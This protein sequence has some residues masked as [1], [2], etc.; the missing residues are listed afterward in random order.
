MKNVLI[1]SLI[2]C[3]IATPVMAHASDFT[4]NPMVGAAHNKAFGSQL[5]LG[6]E[7]GYKDFIL[8]Y[9]INGDKEKN[10]AADYFPGMDKDDIEMPP[11]ELGAYSNEKYRAHQLYMGY[12][13]DTGPGKLAF[14]AGAE[15]SKLK[16][17]SGMSASELIPGGTG[18][19]VGYDASV[20]SNTVIRPMVGV[21]YYLDNGL[22][23]NLHYTFH[24][25]DR[26]MKGSADFYGVSGAN[27]IPLNG[28]IG[29]KDFST[30]MFTVGYRF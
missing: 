29:D 26:D 6:I 20:A 18:M 22:N 13:F 11:L 10:G 14:K 28:S 15:F 9:T 8:G 4:L 5:A 21:G 12:Q 30:V 1:A 25:G 17:K 16:V 7:A 19:E 2:A 23:F 3:S 27:N 24:K